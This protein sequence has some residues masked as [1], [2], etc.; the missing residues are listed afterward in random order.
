MM[1]EDRVQPMDTVGATARGTMMRVPAK[2]QNAK[3]ISQDEL[4]ARLVKEALSS[5]L[6]ADNS[7]QLDIPQE[8]Q[9]T[10]PVTEI[11]PYDRNPRRVMNAQYTSIKDSIRVSKRLTSP[12]VVTR[13]P[14]QEK[15]MVGKGGNTRLSIL[16]ELFAETSD[17][18][19]QYVV[20]TYVPWES[21]S[22]TL[23]AHLVEN[24]LRGEMIFW[25][26]AN[27]YAEMKRL[28][29]AE[30]GHSLSARAFEQ[31]LRDRGL[32]LG[33]AVLGYYLFGVAQLQALQG[34][35]EALSIPKIREL[36]P[37]FLAAERLLK[38]A[39][40]HEAWPAQRDAVLQA[41][42]GR[43]L[44]SGDIDTTA[45]VAT[46]DTHLADL[47]GESVAFV[48]LARA[49]SEHEPNQD[50]SQLLAH[51][52]LQLDTPS[53][54]DP[55]RQNSDHTGPAQSPHAPQAKVAP[56][57]TPLEGASHPMS[58]LQD[59]A[60][61][62]ARMTEVADCLRLLEAWP[63]GFY[64]EVP[65]HDEPIDLSGHGARRYHGWWMLAMLSGQLD[66]AWSGLMPE[67]STWRQAQRQEQGRDDYA[68]QHYMDTILGMPID[69][70][71]LG[72]YLSAGSV[73]VSVWI[74][75]VHALGRW[76]VLA[77]ERFEVGGEA[78]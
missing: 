16:Q 17:P 35:A 66:G 7:G 69:P 39:Q 77:P 58:T 41:T 45:L 37:A 22:A 57:M 53:P 72:K 6:P 23:A 14:G 24:E 12:L 55:P 29:E 34:A 26:K 61:R 31:A 21:E 65:E 47:L 40:R 75:L 68:L 20:V 44:D 30:T 8:S 50:L 5:G 46:L 54:P 13:R 15:F 18:A 73:Q 3:T 49:A 38:H 32:P 78:A 27:A 36:Q 56:A 11:L 63:T 43:W 51:V 10:L 33:R 76:R 67:T 71:T 1:A 52:R 64:M 60:T 70:L 9:M 25:D 48:R 4:R 19:Y 28:L 2:P 59:L 62:F 74:D 42:R